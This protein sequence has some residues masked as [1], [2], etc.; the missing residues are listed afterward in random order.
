[1]R[2]SLS[3]PHFSKWS[4]C[5]LLGRSVSDVIKGRWGL[6][7]RGGGLT[8]RGWGVRKREEGVCWRSPPLSPCAPPWGPLTQLPSWACP[9]EYEVTCYHSALHSLKFGPGLRSP[10]QEHLLLLFASGAAPALRPTL[11]QSCYL[12]GDTA[13]SADLSTVVCPLWTHFTSMSQGPT[14]ASFTWMPPVPLPCQLYVNHSALRAG[15]V[16]RPE[17]D[18][19]PDFQ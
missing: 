16:N 14:G 19:C 6:G 1:M 10:F 11:T 2:G 4:L 5:S 15:A 3:R 8:L 13:P 12:R 7:W 18:R 9:L 17:V